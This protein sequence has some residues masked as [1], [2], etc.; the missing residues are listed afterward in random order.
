MSNASNFKKPPTLS[1][2]NHL[3]KPPA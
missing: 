2:G 3:P 1:L